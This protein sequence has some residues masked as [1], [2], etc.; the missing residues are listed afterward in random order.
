M[1]NKILSLI[2]IFAFVFTGCLSF[3]GCDKGHIY[4]DAY[5]TVEGDV[6]YLN[7]KC[8]CGCDDVE[9]TKVENAI[10]ANPH[11]AQNVLD[12]NINN[13]VIVFDKGVY[14]NLLLIRPTIETVD[15]IYTFT[16]YVLTDVQ[17]LE[18]V[19][20]YYYYRSINNVKMVAVDNA[21]F[22][23]G[24][25]FYSSAN[26]ANNGYKYDPIRDI[27]YSATDEHAKEDQSNVVIQG[28]GHHTVLDVQNLTIEG[29]N[30]TE[31]GY[32]RFYHYITTP[33][34]VEIKN[35]TIK[36]NNLTR[37]ALLDGLRFAG[38]CFDVQ[39]LNVLKDTYILNNEVKNHYQGI[40]TKCSNNVT[41]QGN[42]I[43]NSDHNSIAVQS[44]V[45]ST[46]DV[47]TDMAFKGSVFVKKNK[48]IEAKNISIKLNYGINA[49][50]V[51]EDNQISNTVKYSLA[52][53]YLFQQGNLVNSSYSWN[54]NTLNGTRVEDISGTVGTY[55]W[56][57]YYIPEYSEVTGQ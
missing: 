11:N 9:K 47:E 35:V 2:F 29:L 30:F 19:Q 4:G 6:A 15:A 43:E 31:N 13:S 41:I 20:Q 57:Y 27:C 49:E 52:W 44:V 1:K 36:N 42:V 39:N 8:T 28:A 54:N 16:G 48:I 45:S 17:D 53:P 24:I 10:I 40:L 12:G 25:E 33:R 46:T 37:N 55:S 51:V 18:D 7:K 34:D 14:S 32:I 21:E 22:Q 5:Y 38:I 56:F 23:N 26:H 50:I 3:T